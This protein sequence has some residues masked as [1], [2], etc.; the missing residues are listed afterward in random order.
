MVYLEYSVFG[1]LA[2]L[3]VAVSVIYLWSC[4]KGF[5]VSDDGISYIM[6]AHPKEVTCYPFFDYVF[7]SHLYRWCRGN[8][9]ALRAFVF[10]FNLISATIF[11]LGIKSFLDA[12]G[13]GT[14]M[15]W[16]QSGII[17]TFIYLGSLL[18]FCFGPGTL[19]YNHL[20]AF[21]I[22]ISSGLVMLVLFTFTRLSLFSILPIALL[23]TA[24]I[25]IGTQ[26]FIKISSFLANFAF[27]SLYILFF[28]HFAFFQRF[29]IIL[30]L[31]AGVLILGGFYFLFLQRPKT[32]WS[33]FST[34][35]KFAG[36]FS[37]GGSSITR[38]LKEIKFFILTTIKGNYRLYLLILLGA[39][40]SLIIDQKMIR[41]FALGI[42]LSIL[43]IFLFM[44]WAVKGK[45]YLS[46]MAIYET[47]TMIFYFNFL[48][49]L[50]LFVVSTQFILASQFIV[51]VFKAFDL[52]LFATLIFLLGVPFAGAAGTGN[53]IFTN[54]VFQASPWF[55]LILFLLKVISGSWNFPA[56]EFIPIL[57]LAGFGAVQSIYGFV[58][59]P[60]R[61]N[62]PL[63]KK[64]IA[65][66]YGIPSSKL[67]FDEPTADFFAA[68]KNIFSSAGFQPGNDVI[69]LFNAPGL[70]HAVGGVSPGHQW[71][72]Y[73]PNYFPPEMQD[74][75]FY[76]LQKL[77]PARLK[78]AY[79]LQYGEINFFIDKLHKLNLL[80][81]GE[82]INCGETISPYTNEIVRLWKPI[83]GDQKEIFKLLH[84]TE[85]AIL[86]TR[87]QDATNFLERIL[88][89]DP[90]QEIAHLKL[91]NIYTDTG[92]Y[93]KAQNEYEKVLLF[94]PTS[95]AAGSGLALS[96]F[97]LG[98]FSKAEASARK[99][100]ELNPD[101][102][103]PLR[104]LM[105][106]FK[107][108]GNRQE[109]T[110][111]IEILKLS[112]QDK[113]AL[114]T[115][116]DAYL[117]MKDHKTARTFFE[118]ILEQDPNN[119]NAIQAL[120]KIQLSRLGIMLN[121]DLPV[122]EDEYNRADTF[123]DRVLQSEDIMLFIEQNRKDIPQ[124]VKPLIMLQM[125]QA[126]SNKQDDI[127]EALEIL[128]GV[129]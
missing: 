103:E 78:N 68:L 41:P 71:Y 72:Y 66:E 27:T 20:N 116:G 80:F 57:I 118:K 44:E 25:F 101:R 38:H 88:R 111:A 59:L 84:N 114:N 15:S 104:V 28:T 77:E 51:P 126:W 48:L 96:H 12:S 94:N 61:L 73:A 113:D 4:N 7:T 23:L 90:K 121:R 125:N 98:E 69:G 53:A 31:I 56:F 60:Y 29:L 40:C 33:V 54:A 128:Y 100:H 63:N 9:P 106:I 30:V 6:M 76:H 13:F 109:V 2:L 122:T 36:L 46:G 39:V 120:K 43:S 108:T 85:V 70:I 49:I 124:A 22:L 5:D 26:F 117:E 35:L 112:P 89:L 16:A 107:K 74:F 64:K 129:L 47:P 115:L 19:N 11:F 123:L 21:A 34:Q 87:Y 102:P 62:G 32:W 17:F 18:R 14:N 83:S 110:T 1:I 93:D 42:V 67:Y 10:I 86:A 52:A 127:Y 55:G 99:T 91:A 97:Y 105:Q 58:I 95:L 81:P 45:Y 65:V 50:F 75:N 82:Y 24:G 119:Q 92:D 3:G 8:I 37:W 79:I